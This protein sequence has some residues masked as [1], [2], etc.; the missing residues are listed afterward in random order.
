MSETWFLSEL[1]KNPKNLASELLKKTENHW[2]IILPT[3]DDIFII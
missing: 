3:G 2:E 1:S